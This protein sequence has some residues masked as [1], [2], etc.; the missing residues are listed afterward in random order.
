LNNKYK[1]YALSEIEKFI[2]KNHHLPGIQSAKEIKE[3]GFWNLGEA[4]RINLEKI[5]ELF[6]HTIE[7]EKK[8]KDLEAVNES[9][10][11]EVQTL[12]AQMAEIIKMLEK[13]QE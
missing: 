9:M 11:E 10:S 13:H 1:F 3:Q 6:L 2:K 4:S 12:K 5:E 8:I 7:Q